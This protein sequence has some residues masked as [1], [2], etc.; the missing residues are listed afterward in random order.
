MAVS[1]PEER[2][3]ANFGGTSSTRVYSFGELLR[4]WRRQRTVVCLS[5]P[6]LW[7]PDVQFVY[8]RDSAQGSEGLSLLYGWYLLGLLVCPG[9]RLRDHGRNR[10]LWN[11][12]VGSYARVVH[13]R[14]TAHDPWNPLVDAVGPSV[15]RDPSDGGSTDRSGEIRL[16]TDARSAEA[17]DAQEQLVAGATLREGQK[18]GRLD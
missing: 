13:T 9:R 10:D 14:T 8:V 15:L 16:Q 11:D 5:E 4:V 1:E 3:L 6:R 12:D 17:F 2:P 7:V 18:N